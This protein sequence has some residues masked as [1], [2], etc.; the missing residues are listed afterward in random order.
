MFKIWGPFKYCGIK[1]DTLVQKCSFYKFEIS[2][3]ISFIRTSRNTIRT[4]EKLRQKNYFSKNCGTMWLLV[5]LMHI[6]LL[7]HQLTK[8]EVNQEIGESYGSSY[9]WLSC[10]Y[11]RVTVYRFSSTR[12]ECPTH[13][14]DHCMFSTKIDEVIWQNFSWF[15]L[16]IKYS[17]IFSWIMN[18]NLWLAYALDCSVT[19]IKL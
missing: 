19:L 4:S 5:N 8:F 6:F 15:F 13:W 1:Y 16:L 3:H 9:H 2:R 18:E 12:E 10:N 11:S 7:N 14:Y 17:N